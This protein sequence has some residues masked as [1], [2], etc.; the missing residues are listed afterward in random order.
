MLDH[1]ETMLLGIKNLSNFYFQKGDSESAIKVINKAPQS[2]NTPHWFFLTS[3]KL[4]ISMLS[5]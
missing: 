2:K 4:N 5:D 3:L 1:P